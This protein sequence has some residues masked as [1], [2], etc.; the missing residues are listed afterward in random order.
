MLEEAIGRI[1]CPGGRR[2]F[3]W[4]DRC[5]SA[6]AANPR[7]SPPKR[8]RGQGPSTPLF[9]LAPHG[10]YRASSVSGEA[11]RSYRTLSPLPSGYRGRSTLCG[12]FP[13]VAAAGDYPACILSWSPDLPLEPG[14]QRTPASSST[15]QHTRRG[16]GWPETAGGGSG[17]NSVQRQNSEQRPGT[18]I[19]GSNRGK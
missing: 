16:I 6:R 2:S 10:V 3:I 19:R 12:T 5:R 9:S 13:R 1:L 4:A 7:I 15:G 17:S 11:V 8:I 14:S 18:A